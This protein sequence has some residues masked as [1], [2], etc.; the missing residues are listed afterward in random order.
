VDTA[1]A[2]IVALAFGDPLVDRINGNVQV[3]GAD[4]DAQDIQ[5]F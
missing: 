3:D 4:A 2:D 1:D 5:Q